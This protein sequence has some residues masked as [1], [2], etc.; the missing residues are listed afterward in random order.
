MECIRE[1][2]GQKSSFCIT[3]SGNIRDQPQGGTVAHRTY[4]RI[5][6]RPAKLVHKGFRADPVIS[7]EHHRFLSQFM[8]QI[9]HLPH[10]SRNFTALESHKIFIF[11]A[12]FSVLIIV[13]PLIDDI[14]RPEPIACL[15][16]EFFQN[17]RRYRSGIAVPVHIF[18]PFQFIKDQ[19]KLMEKCRVANHIHVGILLHKPAQ[20][21]QCISMCL[22]LAHIKGDLM[23]HVLPV[24]DH[25][26]VHMHGIPYQIRQ[27]THRIFM[28]RHRL[29]QDHAALFIIILP[30]IRGKRH[31]GT[32]V[33]NLPPALFII[34]GI[35]HQKFL[36][37]PCHQRYLQSPFLRQMKSGHNITLLYFIGIC[38]CPL[39]VLSGRIIGRIDL[40]LHRL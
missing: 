3:Y 12:G 13:I 29:L 22:G 20:T 31:S 8:C 19:R 25:R 26:I 40:C 10:Q 39:I 21:L 27:K 37:D 11:P 18:F 33:H 4:H 24:I 5:H 34:T 16:L 17:I 15:F 35:D 7:Q 9:N 6:A 38:L 14:F 30:F 1:K 28:K 2:V 32:S 36:A 23:F